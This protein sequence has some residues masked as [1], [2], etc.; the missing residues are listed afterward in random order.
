MHAQLY[1]AATKLWHNAPPHSVLSSVYV[2]V[3]M[4]PSPFLIAH[5][6]TCTSSTVFVAMRLA[7]AGASLPAACISKIDT[8]QGEREGQGWLEQHVAGPSRI[9]RTRHGC[10]GRAHGLDTCSTKVVTGQSATK[11]LTACTWDGTI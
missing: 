10:P 5:T 6:H 3:T 9:P 4:P 7:Q 11:G 8:L 1:P 2:Y